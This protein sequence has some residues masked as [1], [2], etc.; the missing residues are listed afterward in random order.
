MDTQ[1]VAIYCICDDIL[2]GLHHTE[3][4]QCQM[5]D[6]E[7]MTTSPPTLYLNENNIK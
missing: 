1:I 4:K 2:K 6:A 7:V 5:S 3:D